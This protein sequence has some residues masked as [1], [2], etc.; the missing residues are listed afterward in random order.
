MEKPAGTSPL[1]SKKNAWQEEL[2]KNFI[3]TVLH[4]FNDIFSHLFYKTSLNI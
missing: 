3:F 2:E 1:F 4:C